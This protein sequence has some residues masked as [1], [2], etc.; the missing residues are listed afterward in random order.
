MD[1]IAE[2]QKDYDA[3]VAQLQDVDR[4]ERELAEKR[5]EIVGKM[6]GIELAAQK[7]SE[8]SQMVQQQR[9]VAFEEEVSPE[10]I[11]AERE[12]E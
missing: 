10:G 1:Y 11:N 4:Q 2:L 8:I 7:F 9:E 3:L 5:Q 6:R 12:S